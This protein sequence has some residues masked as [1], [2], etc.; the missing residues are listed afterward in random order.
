MPSSFELAERVARTLLYEGYHLYPYRLS[1]LKNAERWM[2]GTLYPKGYCESYNR[3]EAFSL[4]AECIVRGCELTKVSVKLRFLQ[5]VLRAAKATG[6]NEA[7]LDRAQE[8][9]T[10][11]ADH[12]LKPLVGAP[13][14]ARFYFPSEDGAC[15]HTEAQDSL[16]GQIS[17][18]ACQL[19][20][21]V[22][23]VSVHV[24]NLTVAEDPQSLST[25]QLRAHCLAS[26]HLMLSLAQ[27]E[28]VS[29]LDPPEPLR[30]VAA[31]CQNVGVF[32]VLI[33]NK[34]CRHLML[35]APIVLYDYPQVAPES[36][37]SFFDSTEIDELL[38][39]RL[40]TLSDQEKAEL[41]DGGAAEILDRAESLSAEAMSKL[42]GRT[43]W[44]GWASVS[45][46]RQPLE[47]ERKAFADRAEQV[48]QRGDRVRL[49]PNRTADIMDIALKG[50]IAVIE[51]IAID[52]DG[53]MH[54]AVVLEDD[55]GREFG[56]QQQPGHRFFFSP[57]ELQFLAP[58]GEPS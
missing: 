35:A 28:F 12:L 7:G 9:Q 14:Y 29:L 42:H 10:S 33:G 6:G 46:S 51:S 20:Q 3:H 23:K 39:L 16:S 36:A 58:A 26:A 30:A 37:G 57:E 31:A 50:Q 18:S 54:V 13:A 40:L 27:G 45:S 32:P 19:E 15:P 11:L 2:W 1:T 21:G 8:R 34:D 55:P 38:V 47:G 52:Y 17:L 43:S 41:R 56:W 25:E 44:Q 48:L 5:W 49:C 22:Y 4:H 53:R 24:E